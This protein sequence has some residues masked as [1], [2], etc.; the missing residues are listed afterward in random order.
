MHH[1]QQQIHP[2]QS[3]WSIS[4]L[5]NVLLLIQYQDPNHQ[6]SVLVS[7]LLLAALHSCHSVG[8]S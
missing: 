2:Q 7:L 3:S 5:L 1:A 8:I 4:I 6:S